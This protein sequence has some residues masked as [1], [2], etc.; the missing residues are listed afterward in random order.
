MPV[1]STYRVNSPMLFLQSATRVQDSI[2]DATVDWMS[3]IS[4][5]VFLPHEADIIKSIPISSRLPPDMLIWTETR[6]GLFTVQSTYNLALNWSLL[7]NRGTSSDNSILRRF[8][9][10]TWSIPVPLKV[11]HFVWRACRDSLPRKAN[12][13]KRK[14]IQEDAYESCKE[15]SETVGHVLWSCLKAKEAWECSKLVLSRNTVAN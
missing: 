3:T 7:T 1:P 8:W 4:D 9:K 6:N 14:I 12:L 15:M 2:D 13:L 11:R 5:A 10:K